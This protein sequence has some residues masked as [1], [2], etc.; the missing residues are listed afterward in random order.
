MINFI[1]PIFSSLI[2]Y[3][4]RLIKKFI[5]K[6]RLIYW[7]LF[8]PDNFLKFKYANE[9]ESQAWKFVISKLKN[10]SSICEIGCFNG[11]IPFILRR[12]LKEKRY[13]GIDINFIAIFIAK[14]FNSFKGHQ[15]FSFHTKK[16]VFASNEKCELFVSVGTLIYFSEKELTT[17]IKSI[18]L[19]K[20]F[21][22]LI[23]HEIF[24]NELFCKS[25]RTYMDDNLNI[26][27]ISMIKEK[28]GNNYDVEFKRT[29]DPNWEKEDRISAILYIKKK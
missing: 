18:K 1:L 29:F 21:K 8:P 24:L 9:A 14:I 12:F 5:R 20:S 16:G 22:A 4:P 23:L 26:H 27:A 25:K 6:N 17:F 19:N 7:T 15:N 2:K 11:R 3:F 13:I 28:F 10:Y